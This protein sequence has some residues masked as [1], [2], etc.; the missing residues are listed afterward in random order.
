MSRLTIPCTVLSGAV[1]LHAVAA[2]TLPQARFEH[3]D[4]EVACDNTRTCRAAGYQTED[5][6]PN[7][8]ILL[9]RHAGPNQPVI[10]ELQ[11]AQAE[12]A[13]A[14]PAT[15][16]MSIA[17]RSLGTIKMDRQNRTGTLSPEQTS[18]LL[19]ALP[20]NEAIAWTAG[21]VSWGI[22]K[23][24]ANAVLL[25][26]DEFQ[27]RLGTPGALIRKGSKPESSVFP[28]LPRPVVLSP[29][30][31]PGQ[32]EPKLSVVQMKGLLAEL[33]KS[34][35]E[36]D[37]E[38][39][40]PESGEPPTL[41]LEA[42]S[43]KA[44]LVSTE[45]WRG[46]YNTGNGYWVV[47]RRAPYSPRFITA[48]ADQHDDGVLTSFHKGRGIGDCI[49]AD[50]WTWDGRSFVHTSTTTTGMCRQFAAGGAWDFPT[51]VSDVR[52]TR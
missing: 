15:L 7:A 44:M 3:K 33:R 1:M 35:K 47:N 50:T 23:M 4:W 24:G 51:L 34:I 10:A 28:A 43:D 45:C 48:D 29:H 27:G 17:K 41:A 42:L 12:D 14:T 31:K 19:E 26:M 8:S 36:V 32:A 46:A 13:S 52:R 38:G 2:D 22:S 11:L 5:V 18:A 40:V 21:K 9:T 30:I 39:L 25:K 37:C 20:N 16:T 49:G 6:V